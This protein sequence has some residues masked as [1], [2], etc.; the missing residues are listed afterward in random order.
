L[1]LHIRLD[2]SI[3]AAMKYWILIVLLVLAPKV[4]F[5]AVECDFS[6]TEM[7]PYNTSQIVGCVDQDFLNIFYSTGGETVIAQVC[8]TPISFAPMAGESFVVVETSSGYDCSGWT[9]DVCLAQSTNDT[10][11]VARYDFS[12]AG[13]PVTPFIGQSSTTALLAS[14]STAIGDTSVGLYAIFAL[15]IALPLMFWF[16]WGVKQVFDFAGKKVDKAMFQE[17]KDISTIEYVEHRMRR[18]DYNLNDNK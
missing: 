16:F 6:T 18:A 11:F 10:T 8:E 7:C 3:I 12:I 1:T 13:Y 15:A 17:Q 4:S 14:V 5:A 2:S 9:L